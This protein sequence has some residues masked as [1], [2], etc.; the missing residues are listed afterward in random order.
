VPTARTT[1]AEATDAVRQFNRFY[2]RVIGLLDEH[3]PES[4][5]S[6]VEGRVL[7][8]IATTGEA[9][10]AADL[11][12]TLGIDKG[13]LSRVVQV[14]EQRRIVAAAAD[15]DHAKR[16]LLGLTA[17]GRSA[18]SLL[19]EGTQRRIAGL[20]APL[21]ATTRRQVVAAMEAIRAAFAER[22]PEAHEVVL[23][24]LEPGDLG[25]VTHRQA[26]LYHREYG[27]DWTYEA[28]VAKILGEYATSFDATK[29]D[30]WIAKQRGQIVGSI[31]LM[32]GPA[33]G[34]AQLR[35][36]YVEPSARGHG[37]GRRL[38][39]VCIARAKE[40]GYRRMTLWTNDVLTAARKIYVRAGF[41]L[42]K[43]NKH[44]SFGKRL[45]GQTWE[46]DLAT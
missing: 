42:V 44:V 21:S 17:R 46:L 32:K 8:E 14:L 25:Y 41:E 38:V 11:S 34:V 10:T 43:E 28:L 30:G 31:F 24:P 45:V 18:F 3:L 1:V 9:L 33:P 27:W 19:D 15:P 36:L 22:A 39:E 26:V 7:Y 35:L 13:Q 6:L 29:E 40:L 37:V 23:G 2:T 12:R 4:E 20:L 5:L 16:K